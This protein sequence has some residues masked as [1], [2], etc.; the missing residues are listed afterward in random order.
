MGETNGEGV[1]G[2]WWH[3]LTHS[4]DLIDDDAYRCVQVQ[5]QTNFA[6]S[7]RHDN[8]PRQNEKVAG[9]YCYFPE[10]FSHLPPSCSIQFKIHEIHTWAMK[11]KEENRTDDCWACTRNILSVFFFFGVTLSKLQHICQRKRTHIT[12][13]ICQLQFL[14]A[15][16][17]LPIHQPQ[18]STMQAHRKWANFLK[19][20]FNSF[21]ILLNCFFNPRLWYTLL[22]W[23]LPQRKKQNGGS[24]K[25]DVGPSAFNC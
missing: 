5:R 9:P 23:P 17:Q 25:K 13:D 18:Q 2:R 12:Y 4:L 10:S 19:R 14:L 11:K 24:K 7:S 22:H 3:W 21:L 1:G 8:H 15:P 16:C 20:S 6:W